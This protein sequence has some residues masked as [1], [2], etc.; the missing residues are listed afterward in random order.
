V[1]E[2][3]RKINTTF[4]IGAVKASLEYKLDDLF[5]VVPEGSDDR[6]LATNRERPRQIAKGEPYI[7]KA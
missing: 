4:I 2:S 7:T 3:K 5:S 1:R 6:R